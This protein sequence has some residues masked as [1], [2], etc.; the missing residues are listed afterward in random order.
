MDAMIMVKASSRVMSA[1]L[2]GKEGIDILK[3]SIVCPGGAG[4]EMCGRIPYRC[5]TL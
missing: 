4:T 3:N 5:S 2:G 1:P